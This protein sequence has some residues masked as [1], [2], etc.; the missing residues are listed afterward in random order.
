MELKRYCE[1][2]R[3]R[4]D[5]RYEIDLRNVFCVNS[6]SFFSRVGFT[7]VTSSGNDCRIVN[8][9]GVGVEKTK[10]FGV[11]IGIEKKFS[12]SK[13]KYMTGIFFEL[14]VGIILK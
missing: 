3:K 4:Y 14:D 2:L 7:L 13:S 9:A 5:Y 6:K 10:F 11:G 12:E 1:Q 8:C